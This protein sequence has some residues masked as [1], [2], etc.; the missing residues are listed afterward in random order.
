VII[1]QYQNA[2]EAACRACVVELQDAE[3]EIDPRLRRGDEIADAYLLQM[4]ARCREHS[5]TILVA[6]RD[7]QIAGLA[8]VL[9][10]VPF[11]SLDQPPGDYAIVAELV[12]R[13]AFRGQG[14]GRALLRAAERFARDAGAFE[15]RIAVLSQNLAARRLYVS[16]DFTP[17]SEVLAKP[18]RNERQ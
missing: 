5:G 15:L 3:R 14:I 18:L 4:H 11:D 8:M 9:A 16:E 7:S 1:R 2:D 17:Y 12:V 6:E 13:T 10:R